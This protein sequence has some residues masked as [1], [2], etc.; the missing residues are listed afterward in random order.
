MFLQN[1]KFRTNQ[2][3]DNIHTD[4]AAGTRG[5]EGAAPPEKSGKNIYIV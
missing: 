5:V 4:I 1:L 2:T 3:M